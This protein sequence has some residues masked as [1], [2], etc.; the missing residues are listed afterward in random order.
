MFDQKHRSEKNSNGMVETKDRKLA[1]IKTTV[2]TELTLSPCFAISKS[3][4]GVGICA[5]G[6]CHGY[7][8]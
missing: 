3:D 1:L 4:I 5:S 7:L 8:G 2:R 6:R